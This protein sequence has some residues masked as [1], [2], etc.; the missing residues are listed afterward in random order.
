MEFST[1][2]CNSMLGTI[3]SS[4]AGSSSFTT[5]SL[6]RSEADDF[7][8]EIVVDEFHFFAQTA[9]TSRRC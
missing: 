9:R 4:D 3:T 5:R 7:D 2:G 8:V 1:S 6:S